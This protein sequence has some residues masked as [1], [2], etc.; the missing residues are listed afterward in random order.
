MLNPLN[1]ISHAL[2]PLVDCV[3]SFPGLMFPAVQPATSFGVDM[4]SRPLSKHPPLNHRIV[5][6]IVNQQ[7]LQSEL[8]TN[9]I[10]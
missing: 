2:L 8:R 9:V 7:N 6:G 1:Y 5:L 3:Y 4:T 10:S